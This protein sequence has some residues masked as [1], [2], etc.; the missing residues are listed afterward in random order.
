MGKYFGT[1]GVRGRANDILKPE[2]AYKLGQAGAHI[3]AEKTKNPTLIIGRDTRISGDLLEHALVAGILST[4]AD[5]IKLGVVPTPAVAHLVRETGSAAGVMI[6]AS[7]N[8]YYDNGIKFFDERGFKLADELEEKIEAYLEQDTSKQ[9]LAVDAEIGRVLQVVGLAD[10]YV[11]HLKT[12]VNNRFERLKIVIDTANGS[13]Y[14]MAPLIFRD[15]GAEVIVI[16]NQPDGL[17]INDKAGSTNLAGLS[18]R[19]LKEKADLGVAYD[20]DADRL[21]AIDENGEIVDGDQLLYIS[22]K[23]LANKGK[24]K[25]QVVV[26]TL[27]S[28]LG[29]HKSFERIGISTR[30]T[31]VGDRYVLEE[32]VES[33]YNLGGEQSGHLIFLDH[34]TTGDGILSSLML[35]DI[36]IERGEKLSVLVGEMEKYPQIL[37]NIRLEDRSKLIANEK[38]DAAVVKANKYLDP[39]GR[40]VV[41]LSGTE[42]LLRVMVEGISTEQIELVMEE[43]MET[44]KAEL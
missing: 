31:Q 26:V 28:N 4:G 16:N 22:G 21:M 1:D 23:Q 37:K 24:L 34:N 9:D 25:R 10:K 44:I 15:L 42:P 30:E 8:P 41:R 7:H 17:N 18:A 14:E 3:I 11:E 13:A 6:S 39:V 29:L 40:V 2:L 33:D 27:M 32:M 12:T 36:L 19:V 35:A 20:G 5:V 38:I 43:L